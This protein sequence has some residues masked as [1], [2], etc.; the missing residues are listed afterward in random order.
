MAEAF[1]IWLRDYDGPNKK[2][3]M[4]GRRW[5]NSLRNDYVKAGAYQEPQDVYWALTRLYEDEPRFEHLVEIAHRVY[6]GNLIATASCFMSRH[7]ELYPDSDVPI[8][9]ADFDRPA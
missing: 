2:L 5:R 4:L 7:K 6:R 3:R 1:G 8:Y 9:D